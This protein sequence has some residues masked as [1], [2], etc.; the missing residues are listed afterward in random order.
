M[1]MCMF[2]IIAV[3]NWELYRKFHENESIEEYV[4]YLAETAGFTR[5]KNGGCRQ[6]KDCWNPVSGLQR[7]ERPDM[8]PDI[9]I[10]REKEMGEET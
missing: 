4:E 10:V 2:K 3:S 7:Q 8:R 9:L 6:E 5:E 1:I